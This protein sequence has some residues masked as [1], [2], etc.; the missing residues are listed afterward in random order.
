M[1]RGCLWPCV[2]LSYQLTTLKSLLT[3]SWHQVSTVHWTGQTD[4]RVDRWTARDDLINDGQV[5]S[6]K[7]QKRNNFFQLVFFFLLFLSWLKMIHTDHFRIQKLAFHCSF[8]STSTHDILY[9]KQPC[10]KDFQKKTKWLTDITDY[11]SCNDKFTVSTPKYV[12]L[13]MFCWFNLV[14]LVQEPTAGGSGKLVPFSS[15]CQC[16]LFSAQNH[17]IKH[18]RDTKVIKGRSCLHHVAVC[19]ANRSTFIIVFIPPLFLETLWRSC[20]ITKNRNI[21]PPKQLF[22]SSVIREDV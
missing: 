13:N 1:C 18:Q 9:H 10:K 14:P 7:A 17:W 22:F 2:S 11:N 21:W 15:F 16:C 20:K 8:I 19:T 5:I 12:G 6:G 4:E 3:S